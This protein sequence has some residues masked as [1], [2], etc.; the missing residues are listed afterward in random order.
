LVPD[1]WFERFGPDTAVV[2][3]TRT[4]YRVKTWAD[5]GREKKQRQA[6]ALAW[7]READGLAIRPIYVWVF[8][9][10]G[11]GGFGY[12]GWW[13]YLVG[14]NWDLWLG[15]GCEDVHQQ[16]MDL[17]PLV[18]PDLF[19]AAVT[20]EQ[21]QIRFARAFCC[22]HPDGRSRKHA[23]RIQ[24]K[25]AVWAEFEGQGYGGFRRIIGRAELCR[26]RAR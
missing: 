2:I 4:G 10:P 12:L 25:A 19:G 20:Y 18:E 16:L 26:E 23:G 21:W 1:E 13:T 3:G 6:R 14:R 17:F 5:L 9:C 24:G 15:R 7:K 11:V 22:R 8:H